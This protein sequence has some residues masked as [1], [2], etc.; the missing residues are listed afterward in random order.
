MNGKLLTTAKNAWR[1]LW[2]KNNCTNKISLYGVE[3]VEGVELEFTATGDD[4]DDALD[5][6]I[7]QYGHSSEWNNFLA[8][9]TDSTVPDGWISVEDEL[10]TEGYIVAIL[11]GSWRNIPYTGYLESGS[12]H[13]A[14]GAFI[15][16][17]FNEVMFWAHLPKLPKQALEKIGEP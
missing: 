15:G 7:E 1:Y 6:D 10:P 16:S 8:E 13:D 11:V 9:L 17:G 5:E 2:I 12:W 4:L 3:G 14:D